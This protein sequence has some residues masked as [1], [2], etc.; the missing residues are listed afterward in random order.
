M[1]YSYRLKWTKLY[2]SVSLEFKAFE[3]EMGSSLT[4]SN[5]PEKTIT[6]PFE[7]IPFPPELYIPNP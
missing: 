3:D 1:R 6:G 2:H 5:A 7:D 4:I